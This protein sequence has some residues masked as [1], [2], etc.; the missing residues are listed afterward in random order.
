M[1]FCFEVEPKDVDP[2]GHDCGRQATP[3]FS[4]KLPF[5]IA[6]FFDGRFPAL[7]IELFEKVKKTVT[8]L[9]ISIIL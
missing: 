7:G 5:R 1:P 8:N 3:D 4:W 6:L 2:L 9:Q